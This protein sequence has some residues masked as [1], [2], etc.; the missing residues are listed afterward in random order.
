MITGTAS[1]PTLAELGD[2]ERYERFDRL[3]ERMR[4]VWEIMRHNEEDESGRC[5]SLGKRGPG[6]RAKWLFAAG[7]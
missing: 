6:E 3:Q 4:G 1:G 2:E 7:V 5:H